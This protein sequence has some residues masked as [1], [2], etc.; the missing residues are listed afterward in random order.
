MKRRITYAETSVLSWMESGETFAEAK[1][2]L[3]TAWVEGMHPAQRVK[4]AQK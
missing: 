1:E 4:E 2:R 3:D